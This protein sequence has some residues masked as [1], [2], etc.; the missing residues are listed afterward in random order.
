MIIIS[1]LC[2]CLRVECDSVVALSADSDANEENNNCYIPGPG[3]NLPLTALRHCTRS[4]GSVVM[5]MPVQQTIF[6]SRASF[7]YDPSIRARVLHVKPDIVSHLV[8]G[9][10]WRRPG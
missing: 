10:G 1:L 2:M 5:P 9:V 8:S 3:E 7:V 6:G 4:E